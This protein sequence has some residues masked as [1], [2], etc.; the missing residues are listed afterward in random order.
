VMVPVDCAV[1]ANVKLDWLW[2][3]VAGTKELKE[4][5]VTVIGTADVSALSQW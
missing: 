2:L 4:E 3:K 1:F 5:L